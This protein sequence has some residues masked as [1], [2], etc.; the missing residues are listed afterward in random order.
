[1][2]F[3]SNLHNSLHYQYPHELDNGII[4]VLCTPHYAGN[5]CLFVHQLQELSMFQWVHCRIIIFMQRD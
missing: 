2:A 3:D 4:H 1:M 5:S